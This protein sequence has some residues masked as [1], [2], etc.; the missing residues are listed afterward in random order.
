MSA[1]A[2]DQHGFT[3]VELLIAIG[4][5]A[6]LG[7]LA[8]IMLNGALSNQQIV[9]ERQYKLERVALALHIMRRDL[10]QL[11]PRVGRD[12]YGDPMAARIV[13]EQV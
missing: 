1:S 5:M 12:E 6:L 9:G 3:L 13:A 11:T 4:I 8:S 7:A 10:E 2:R